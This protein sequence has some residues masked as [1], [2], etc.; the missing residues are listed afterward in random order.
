VITSSV[1]IEATRSPQLWPGWV[2]HG[3]RMAQVVGGTHTFGW[4]LALGALSLGPIGRLTLIGRV[5]LMG[6]LLCAIVAAIDVWFIEARFMEVMLVQS[7]ARATDDVRLGLLDAVS[8]ADFAAPHTPER[9]ADL[10]ARLDPVLGPM[11][12]DD[13]GMLELN[14]VASDQTIIYSSLPSVAGLHLDLSDQPLLSE[15]LDGHVEFNGGSLAPSEALALKTVR[16]AKFEV[17]VPV[18]VDGAIVGAYE[19][20]EDVSGFRWIRLAVWTA[21]TGGFGVLLHLAVRLGMDQVS[22]QNSGA[23][24]TSTQQAKAIPSQ[25]LTARELEV[26]GLLAAGYSY[27]TLAAELT[28]SEETVRSHVK[29]ILHKLGQ[30]N[31]M[32]AV[33]AALRA[34]IIEL[35]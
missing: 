2:T 21:L 11:S 33:V 27:R 3:S 24:H 9:L 20:Y 19:V 8:A 16:D 14:L 26:L 28:L 1:K 35:P 17:Y 30:P 6:A 23:N 7:A 25:P 12:N 22:R 15:A 5:T 29:R 18:V 10:K 31:R 13:S 32:A 4:L 34:G